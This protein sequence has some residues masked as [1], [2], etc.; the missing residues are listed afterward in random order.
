MTPQP[1]DKV[2]TTTHVV[3]NG[4]ADDALLNASGSYGL[5]PPDLNRLA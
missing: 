1:T 2:D 4:P 3:V 5:T